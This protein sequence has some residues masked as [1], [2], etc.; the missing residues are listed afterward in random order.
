ME[1]KTFFLQ[2]ADYFAA[3]FSGGTNG[4]FVLF[5]RCMRGARTL[6]LTKRLLECQE[7]WKNVIN[8][9]ET[10]FVLIQN[11]MRGARTLVFMRRQKFW[12]NV[13]NHDGMSEIRMR[14]C[15][16]Y[17]WEVHERP[18]SQTVQGAIRSNRSTSN[19]FAC[20]NRSTCTEHVL[21]DSTTAHACA[22][23]VVCC[24]VLYCLS[25]W[26]IN[27]SWVWYI[28]NIV[29]G[30]TEY[31]VQDARAHAQALETEWQTA[32]GDA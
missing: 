6:I 8:S 7:F 24:F 31:F 10:L 9:Q 32:V 17:L 3:F 1:L 16:F 12:W 29:R 2:R 21:R 14:R 22:V 20:S 25:D 19:V 13:K 28:E 27:S 15:L 11:C 5:R 26:V 18:S 23:C 4:L 30:S